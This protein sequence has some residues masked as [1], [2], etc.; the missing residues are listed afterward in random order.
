MCVGGL[1]SQDQNYWRFTDFF[2]KSSNR[3]KHASNSTVC[4]SLAQIMPNLTVRK[5][6]RQIKCKTSPSTRSDT[7]STPLSV[8]K[9]VKKS[10]NLNPRDI[11]VVHT[12][13]DDSER[14]SPP[15]IPAWVKDVSNE[16]FVLQKSCMLGTMAVVEDSDFVR[17]GEFSFRQF[18]T[19]AIRKLTKASEEAKVMFEWMSGKAVISSK[20]MRIAD[21]LSIEVEDENCWRKVEKRVERWMLQS[22]KEIV[23]KLTI[24]YKKTGGTN[25]ESSDEDAP[26]GKKV[27]LLQ[28]C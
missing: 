12:V 1:Y 16:I 21:S 22:K 18:E 6:G 19:S 24:L 8:P 7:D 17:L 27:Q 10:K 25:V 23:V 9:R 2:T 3:P 11:I 28:C 15:P 20:S 26:S 4:R 14:E 5:S 13:D